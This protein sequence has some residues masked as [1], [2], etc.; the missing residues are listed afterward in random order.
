MRAA[1]RN[2][3]QAIST[4]HKIIIIITM[5]MIISIIRLIVIMHILIVI[6][7]IIVIVVM[8]TIYPGGRSKLKLDPVYQQLPQRES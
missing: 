2:E 1:R 6:I 8:I 7:T 3:T 5:I 4:E